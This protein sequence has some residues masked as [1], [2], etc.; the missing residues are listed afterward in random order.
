MINTGECVLAVGV[1]GCRG[2]YL[3][4]RQ[5]CTEVLSVVLEARFWYSIESMQHEYVPYYHLQF[6][7]MI[8]YTVSQSKL[9]HSQL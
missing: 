6:Y 4:N 9:C 8:H 5:C 3:I 7:K 1:D 2:V